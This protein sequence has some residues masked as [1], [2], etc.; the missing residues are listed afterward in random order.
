MKTK[1]IFTVTALAALVVLS[2]CNLLPGAGASAAEQTLE[3]LYVQQTVDALGQEAQEPQEPQVTDTPAPTPT[4]EIVHTIT[5]GN[6]DWVSQYWQEISSSGTAPENRAP[7]GDFLSQNLLERPFTS[8]DMDYRPD[9]DL[10]R[11]ELSHDDTFY[12]FKLHLEGENPDTGFLAAFYGVE[13][14]TDRDGRG[15]V[16]LWVRGDGDTE[17]NIA[18]VM[19]YRDANDDVGG[20]RPVQAD[21]PGG[22][23]DG[24]ETVLFSPENPDDPDAA[25]KREHPSEENVIQL[26]VK[27]SMQGG[28][29]AF[30]WLGWADDGVSDP[31]LFDYNDAFTLDDAGSPLSNL[32]AYPVKELFLA[33]NTCRIA[34]GFEP[35]GFEAGGCVLPTPTPTPA[36][37]TATP[38]P[39]PTPT[40]ELPIVS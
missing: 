33:D 13:F 19:V 31:A 36:P 7:G 32:D 8:Q 28:A 9:T 18:D 20:P 6:P 40:E 5:S 17:W 4:I 3:A 21:A 38:E 23:G 25:W 16:L 27:K 30:M 11:V 10:V 29:G 15:D 2:G 14:D 35:T 34:W 39:T 22:D 37:P 24:Y 12:Y 26:A 1:Q